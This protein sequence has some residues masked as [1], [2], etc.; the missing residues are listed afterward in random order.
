MAWETSEPIVV[1]IDFSGMSVHAI[2]TAQQM[3][4]DDDLIHVVH[5]VPVLDQILPGMQALALPTD[6]DRRDA[7]R[8]HFSEFLAEHGFE[9][10][11]DIMLD[12]RPG[13]E[14]SEYAARVHAG[15]IVIPSHGYHGVKRLL[16]GSVAEQV[17]RHAECPVFVLRRPDA[18]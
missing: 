2:K 8:Q 1:P 11:R 7:V 16:L 12:G 14:I 15:L 9:N 6:D 17:I 5:V 4:M 18:E 13:S 3:A 10:V